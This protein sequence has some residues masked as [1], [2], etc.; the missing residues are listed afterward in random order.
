LTE[1]YTTSSQKAGSF[2]FSKKFQ[3][4]N[5]V[6]AMN[7]VVTSHQLVCLYSPVGEEG[8]P[9]RQAYWLIGGPVSTVNFILVFNNKLREGVFRTFGIQKPSYFS[10]IELV[11]EKQPSTT[12]G[13]LLGVFF[14]TKGPQDEDIVCK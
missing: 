11:M 10:R 13:L 1:G 7:V 4:H 5:G 2:G 14:S 3:Q 9:P 6:V 8:K 12:K